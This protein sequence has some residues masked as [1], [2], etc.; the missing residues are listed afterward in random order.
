[1]AKENLAL[2][3]LDEGSNTVD[4]ESLGCCIYVFMWISLV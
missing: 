3:I 2:E 4:T 1:M